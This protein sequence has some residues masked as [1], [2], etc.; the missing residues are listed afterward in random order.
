M[1]CPRCGG[2]GW[3][4][5]P[6]QRTAARCACNPERPS[7]ADPD[8]RRGAR[9]RGLRAEREL[10]AWLRERGFAAE[11]G[12]QRQGGAASPDLLAAVLEFHPEVKHVERLDLLAALRQAKR[13]ARGGFYGVVHRTSASEWH[14][15]QPL[16]QYLALRA[17]ESEGS[18]EE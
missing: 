2:A 10:A 7:G 17:G 9:L 13:D 3:L 18:A 8:A 1:S 12:A 16:E 11:A 5:D 14:V 6:V 4:T 15:T